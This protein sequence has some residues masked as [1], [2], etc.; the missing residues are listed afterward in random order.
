MPV[1]KSAKKKLKQ[2]RKR[3]EQNKKFE[4]LLKTKL[5][6]VKKNPSEKTIQEAIKLVDKAAKKRLIHKNKASR[7]KSKLSKLLAL[8]TPKKALPKASKKT[9][10]SK[11]KKA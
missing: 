10:K 2:D 6:R 1:T 4:E 11:A 5:K 8:K 7:I 3:R 9:K